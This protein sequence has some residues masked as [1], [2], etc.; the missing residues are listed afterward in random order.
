ME[1]YKMDIITD[2]IIVDILISI[3]QITMVATGTLN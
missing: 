3:V 1:K 2:M